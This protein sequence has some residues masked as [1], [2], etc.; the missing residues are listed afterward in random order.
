MKMLCVQKMLRKVMTHVQA[1][2]LSLCNRTCTVQLQ[3]QCQCLASNIMITFSF[4]FFQAPCRR[5]PN[6]VHYV[7]RCFLQQLLSLQPASECLIAEQRLLNCNSHVWRASSKIS[8]E[9][10]RSN[11]YLLPA[12]HTMLKLQ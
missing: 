7:G 3:C 1:C 12:A 6:Y 5:N 10:L 4:N 11:C 8:K 2:V 9:F